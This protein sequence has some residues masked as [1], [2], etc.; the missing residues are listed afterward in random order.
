MDN[1][2]SGIDFK[3]LSKLVLCAYK[4]GPFIENLST[5]VSIFILRLYLAEIRLRPLYV[6][7][8]CLHHAVRFLQFRQWWPP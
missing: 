7:R 8:D 4:M 1:S 5:L 3:C 2:V 6:A